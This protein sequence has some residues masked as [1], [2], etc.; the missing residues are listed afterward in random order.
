MVPAHKLWPLACAISL[1]C[2]AA[3]VE[4]DVPIKTA[5]APSVESMEGGQATGQASNE[6]STR[7]FGDAKFDVPA[8]WEEK[9]AASSVL[10]GEFRVPGDSGPARLTLSTAGGGTASNMDRWKGQFQRGPSDTEPKEST[11]TI[12]GKTATLIE[13]HGTFNDTF[14]GGGPKPDSELLGVAIPIDA[15]HN[16]F[17]KLTG[18][19]S[20]IEAAREK[21]TA[22]VNSARFE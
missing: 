10:L 5:K 20:T 18:P 6:P 13:I 9:P 12:D 7:K 14:G 16:Y 17:I 2:G 11:L 4:K 1:G 3:P 19:K 21:F 15:D 22:F 8:G